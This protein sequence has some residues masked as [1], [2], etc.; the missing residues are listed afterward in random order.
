MDTYYVKRA[1]EILREEGPV[2]LA[3]ASKRFLISRSLP[4]EQ[5][6]RMY[7]LRKVWI[8]SHTGIGD[9]LRVYQVDPREIQYIHAGGGVDFIDSGDW[10][11]EGKTHVRDWF[12]MKLFSKHFELGIPWGEIDEYQMME[13]KIKRCGYIEMLDLPKDKQSVERLHEYYT[14]IDE[15]YNT[16]KT[17]GYKSQRELDVE[18]DFAKRDCHPALNEIQVRISRD[19]EIMPSTGYHRF[20]IAKILRI[21]SVPV[22]TRARHLEW[23]KLRDE[24]HNNGLP[25]GHEDLRDHPELQDILN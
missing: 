18:D 22:R 3:K 19:G 4:V 10:D 5:R 15:L 7:S 23:Q 24:T 6:W 8:E 21:N 11:I 2:K 16:I 17:S 12:F 14:Y 13:D 20:T 9:P 1:L 25:E